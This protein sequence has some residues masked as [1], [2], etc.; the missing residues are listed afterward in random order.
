MKGSDAFK[1]TIKKY[2]DDMADRNEL[3]KE[4]YANPNK[5]IEDC[6]TY[7]LNTVQKTQCNGFEDSEIYSMAVHYYQE[8]NVE[9][10]LNTLKVIQCYGPHN[11][12]NEFTEPT[13]SLINKNIN[14]IQK[15]LKNGNPTRSIPRSKKVVA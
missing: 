13:I 1:A 12:V 6:I 10:G 5:N 15:R 3:F 4:R 8:D 14:Q 11:E 9:I 7:I 2:L